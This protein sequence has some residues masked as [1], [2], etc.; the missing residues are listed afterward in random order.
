[1]LKSKI[2]QLLLTAKFAKRGLL[3]SERNSRS[4][5]TRERSGSRES[6]VCRNSS[7]VGENLKS[8]EI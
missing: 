4:C 3:T 1:M 6:L 7:F 2:K 8:Q 5:S